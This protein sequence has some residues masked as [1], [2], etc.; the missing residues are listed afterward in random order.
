MPAQKNSWSATPGTRVLSALPSKLY[1]AMYIA[2]GSSEQAR[3]SLNDLSKSLLV[4]HFLEDMGGAAFLDPDELEKA[5]EIADVQIASPS[6]T[7]MADLVD[8]FKNLDGQDGLAYFVESSRDLK[9]IS[10]KLRI[11]S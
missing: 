7:E 9:K 5:K 4:R 8:S 2:L 3:R 10:T 6:E 1:V 11:A